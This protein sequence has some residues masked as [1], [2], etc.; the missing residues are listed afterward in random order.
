MGKRRKNRTHLKGANARDAHPDGVPK[1]FIIKHGQVG[2]SLAQ[3]VR[4]MRKVMEPNTASRLKERHRNKLKDYLTMAPA[5]Q[6]SHLL[7]FTLT[8]LAPS[9]RM[10]RLSN[11]P[12]LSFRVE[13]YSLMK[14]VLKST[15][16]ARTA[17][18][19]YLT[20]PLLVLASF[21]APSPS[22]PPQLPLLMKSFQSLFPPLSPQTLSL[23]QARR[24]VLVS[25][26]QDRG[27]VDF[28]HY[29]ITVKPYGV[30]RRVR[31]ILEGGISVQS[32]SGLLDLGNEKDVADFVLR[33]RGEP[34]PDGYES[35]SSAESVAGDENAAVDLAE[36]YVG[37]NNKKGQR[38]AV[39]LD[40]VGPR[41][42]LKL[43]KITEGVPGKEG[44]VIYHEFVK[45]SKKEAAEQASTHAAK[46][47]LRKERR[48]EQER[49]VQ[50]KKVQTKDKNGEEVEDHEGDE[51][52]MASEQ[53]NDDE[54]VWDEDEEIS[55]GE[56]SEQEESEE[57]SSED[58]IRPP[59]TKKPRIKGK[60]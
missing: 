34:G 16:R 45:K 50:R 19:Q 7:A 36:D 21:P 13:R 39:R 56:D 42:E 25:Y 44:A 28:R 24:V 29:I 27:T 3:L 37:R 55:E 1:T 23:S 26:N 40:E 20:P 15:R 51:N 54:G 53:A 57:E 32:T 17:G 38:R 12:T 14:D 59:P 46:E 10:V 60:R 47:K 52:E 4:D 8:P 6:V 49:N 22:T 2:S 30:S 48:E 9:L 58:E 5:L 33:K 11:G 35:A 31:K 43:I 41:M 18:I